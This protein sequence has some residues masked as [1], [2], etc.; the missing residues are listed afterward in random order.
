MSYLNMLVTVIS[1][2]KCGVKQ[3]EHEAL[4]LRLGMRGALPPGVVP[5]LEFPAAVLLLLL[6][7][8]WPVQG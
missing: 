1:S 3:S 5:Y 4:L 6:L 8:A 7:T 2:L